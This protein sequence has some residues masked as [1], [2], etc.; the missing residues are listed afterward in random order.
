MK[1]IQLPPILK[2]ESQK[3]RIDILTKVK[4]TLPVIESALCVTGYL[5]HRLVVIN[6]ESIYV[7]T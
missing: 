6:H 7:E 2:H 4:L 3:V 1:V 5:T